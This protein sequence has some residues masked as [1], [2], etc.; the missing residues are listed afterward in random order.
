MSDSKKRLNRRSFMSRVAGA[1]VLAGGAAGIVTGTAKAQNYTGRTDSDS[2]SNAD[3][4]GYGRTGLSDSDSG[5]GA[6]R[7]GYGRGGHQGVTDH[8]TGAYA[9]PAGR[10]RGSSGMSDSDSGRYADPAG[11][12]RG[13]RTGVTDSDSGANR[14]PV[15]RGRGGGRQNGVTDHDIVQPL[16]IADQTLVFSSMSKS[17]LSS[18][19]PRCSLMSSRKSL[20]SSK[21]LTLPCL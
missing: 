10:G 1:A 19:S 7:A 14:D 6:D 20:S 16:S 9:D 11:R 18:R 17:S 5:S 3:R 13:G 8:D 15:G 12:G 2:G 4:S 21:S